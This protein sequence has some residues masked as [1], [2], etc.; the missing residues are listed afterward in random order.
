MA[1]MW[2]VRASTV[3]MPAGTPCEAPSLLNTQLLSFYLRRGLHNDQEDR[4]VVILLQDT[5]KT[6]EGYL[7]LYSQ[8]FGMARQE[9]QNKGL[10]LVPFSDVIERSL[11]TTREL[12]NRALVVIAP[13][14]TASIVHMYFSQPGTAL[15]EGLCQAGL[16]PP[17]NLSYA[18]FAQALGLRY[19]AVLSDTGCAGQAGVNEF[20]MALKF[21]LSKIHVFKETT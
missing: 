9:T 3:Y 17:P 15:I 1:L 20:K 5:T 14:S 10:L 13:R 8:V 11:A 18:A 6:T 21:Y 2:G 4:N 16:H 12:F 7:K 19:Y